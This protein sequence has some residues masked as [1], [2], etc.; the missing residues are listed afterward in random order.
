MDHSLFHTTALAL[1][2]DQPSKPSTYWIA[3][4]IATLKPSI[5]L[6][7]EDFLWVKCHGGIKVGTILDQYRVKHKDHGSVKLILGNKLLS[8]ES[9]RQLD[10]FNDQLL[11]FEAVKVSELSSRISN[12][13]LPLQPT[14][15]QVKVEPTGNT[16]TTTIK[17]DT[18]TTTIKLDTLTPTI[19]HENNYHE[20][21]IKHAAHPAEPHSTELS[22]TFGR[23]AWAISNGFEYYNAEMRAK[24]QENRPHLTDG[25]VKLQYL[26]V[27]LLTSTMTYSSSRRYFVRSVAETPFR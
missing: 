24:F 26:A 22:Q 18:P 10:E 13:R 19:K 17:H 4:L 23:P 14:N 20:M 25:M 5:N 16:P 8:D 11:A 27:H 12:A 3:V 7:E 1:K 9:M 21:P 2:P 15:R 6:K